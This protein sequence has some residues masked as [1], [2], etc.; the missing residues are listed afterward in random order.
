MFDVWLMLGFGALGYLFD[1]ARIPTAPLV[2][3]LVLGPLLD[4]SLAQ[5]LLIGYG[6]WGVF[7]ESPVAAGLLMLAALSILQAT[8]FFGL[9]RAA[10]RNPERDTSGKDA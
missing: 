4:T 3:G 8:P 2:I 10:R 9:F 7:M 5:S 6:N 1:R